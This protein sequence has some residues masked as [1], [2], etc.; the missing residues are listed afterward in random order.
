MA[1]TP[2]NRALYDAVVAEARARYARFP[3]AYASA[4]ISREYKRRGGKYREKRRNPNRGVTRWLRERWVQVVPFLTRGAI[5]PCGS[6]CRHAKACRP[7]VRVTKATPPTLPE[8]QALHSKAT[9][10]R[11]ARAKGRDMA[12]RVY[13]KRGTIS[14]PRQ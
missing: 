7:L 12:R 3:S 13:W 14:P 8:L 10:L 4:W 1:P 5:V 2:T 9:L 11:L 6:A